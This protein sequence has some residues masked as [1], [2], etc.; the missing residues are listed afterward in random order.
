MPNISNI[1]SEHPGSL[2]I[3]LLFFMASL[4]P[5]LP[6]ETIKIYNIEY[7]FSCSLTS[8]NSKQPPCNCLAWLIEPF[9]IPQVKI[10]RNFRTGKISNLQK[11]E[12]LQKCLSNTT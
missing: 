2:G 4:C 10:P 3:F 6:I 1:F 12:G 5:D 7:F 9:E 11:F 8:R